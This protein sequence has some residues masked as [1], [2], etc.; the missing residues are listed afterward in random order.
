[1]RGG[2]EAEGK[3]WAAWGGDGEERR[4][5]GRKGNGRGK[6]ILYPGEG[7]LCTGVIVGAPLALGEHG[8]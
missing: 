3:P 7:G 8:R 5:K 4:G 1:M 2:E 6:G